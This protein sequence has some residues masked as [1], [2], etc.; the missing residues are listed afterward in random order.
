MKAATG[1]ILRVAIAAAALAP[2][3]AVCAQI[4]KWVDERGVTNYSNQQP[5]SSDAPRTV[6]VVENNISVYT[7]D[8]ALTRAVDAFRMRSNEIGASAAAPAAPPPYDYSAPVFVPV[9]V[10]PDPCGEYRAAGCNEFYP[11]FYPYAPVAGYGRHFRRH[12]R[13]PQARIPP[14]TIAGQVVGMDGFIPGNSA[15]APRFG[16]S[17]IRP[18]LRHAVEPSYTGGRPAQLPTRFR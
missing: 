7:P 14:G 18:G 10:A 5:A 15:N 2:L 1:M 13:I 17:P 12:K 9:P 6:G 3:P 11:D 16:P 4:Y 8:P